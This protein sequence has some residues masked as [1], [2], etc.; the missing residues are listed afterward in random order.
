M[1]KTDLK[2]STLQPHNDRIMVRLDPLGENVVGGIIIASVIERRQITGVVTKLGHRPI[3][4]LTG[5]AQPFN[6]KEG[7]KVALLNLPQYQHTDKGITHQLC[8]EGDILGIIE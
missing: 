4:R 2:L 1:L 3:D 7:D 6:V 5:K 8:L